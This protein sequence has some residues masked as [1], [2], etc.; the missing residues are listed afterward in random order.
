MNPILYFVTLEDEVGPFTIVLMEHCAT[1]QPYAM[2]LSSAI[3]WL[4]KFAEV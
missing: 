3:V 4:E 2:L 1:C